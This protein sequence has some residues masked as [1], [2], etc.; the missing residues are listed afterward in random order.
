MALPLLVAAMLSLG[1]TLLAAVPAWAQVATNPQATSRAPTA[2]MLAARSRDRDEDLWS[3]DDVAPRP[4]PPAT[5]RTICVR[6][7]DGYYFPISFQTTRA[8]L[9]TDAERCN[10]KCGGAQLFFHANPGGAVASARSFTGLLYEN[11]PNAFRHLKQ[12]VPGCG[13]KPEPWSAEEQRRHRTYAEKERA[14]VAPP[15]EAEAAPPADE[16]QERPLARLRRA[17]APAEPPMIGA[18][19]PDREQRFV[20]RRL[21]DSTR[22][23]N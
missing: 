20:D 6:L 21:R 12:R 16:E 19:P 2:A 15:P 9:D 3:D 14:N 17:P 18:T 11:L 23:P 4:R 10:A 8:G 7:C 1:A 22:V 5:F 13:C